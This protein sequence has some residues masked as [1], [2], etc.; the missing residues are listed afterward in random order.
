MGEGYWRVLTEYASDTSFD[1]EIRI[2]QIEN[3]FLRIIR[4]EL[5][6]SR[7]IRRGTLHCFRLDDQ[8][9][10]QEDVSRCSER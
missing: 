7:W 6:S 4:P 9:D 3:A 2:K 1:Q 5:K 8:E 10:V